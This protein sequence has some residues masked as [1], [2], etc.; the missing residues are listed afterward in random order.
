MDSTQRAPREESLHKDEKLISAIE[1][2]LN[3]QERANQKMRA[4]IEDITKSM[5]NMYTRIDLMGQQRQ[6]ELD[7]ISN[8]LEMIERMIY[9]L[10]YNVTS[11]IPPA[12]PL[13]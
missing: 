8:R 6:V 5:R 13:G 1:E 4:D 3:A 10:F 2:F 11:T 9:W 7:N 12:L